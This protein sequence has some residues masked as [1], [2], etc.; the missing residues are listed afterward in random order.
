MQTKTEGDSSRWS[1]SLTGDG[2]HEG[3]GA[4]ER[5]SLSGIRYFTMGPQVQ[6]SAVRLCG[7][8]GRMRMLLFL[9]LS[10]YQ[11]LTKA[12]YLTLPS[13]FYLREHNVS[14]FIWY[15]RLQRLERN[16][17]HSNAWRE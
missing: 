11:K 16:Y 8:I 9:R 1:R 13:T 17:S 15:S 14:N 6:Y 7:Y 12:F 5:G 4:S 2:G 3:Q 10:D